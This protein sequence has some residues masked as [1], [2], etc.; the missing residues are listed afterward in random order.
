M[1]CPQRTT[2]QQWDTFWPGNICTEALPYWPLT[3][4]LGEE[5]V[6]SQILCSHCL[7][8]TDCMPCRKYLV[9]REWKEI[10]YG[11]LQID[12]EGTNLVVG[13]WHQA[14]GVCKPP[15]WVSESVPSWLP[16][17]LG[18]IF[19]KDDFP[20]SYPVLFFFWNPFLL[21]FLSCPL[22]LWLEGK[23]TLQ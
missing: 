4:W 3:K 18:Y 22:I 11:I 21:S 20:D 8:L 16:H 14:S 5:L 2:E 7:P 9:E 6:Q 1:R 23:N 19:M 15:A 12:W 10:S 13:I 17:Y